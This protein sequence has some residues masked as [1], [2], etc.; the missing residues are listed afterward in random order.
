MAVTAAVGGAWW[1]GVDVAVL[2]ALAALLAALLG[3]A[4][5]R[6]RHLPRHL[7]A[8]LLVWPLQG[9]GLVAAL[10]AAGASLD[11]PL[12]AAALGASAGAVALA[13][14]TPVPAGLGVR[15]LLVVELLVHGG[16]GGGVAA[17]G[18]LLWRA[19]TAFVDLTA[20]A[21]GLLARRWRE[22]QSPAP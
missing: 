9:L 15:D 11:G 13:F 16:V 21:V 20:T 3:F 5:G 18:A 22:Q 2:L 7:W 6:W 4:A 10:A 12:V 17:A 14:V 8:P 1:L 19:S